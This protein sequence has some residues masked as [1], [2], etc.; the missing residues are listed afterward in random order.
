MAQFVPEI[1]AI[2]FGTSN[3][4]LAAANRTEVHHAVPLDPQAE[5]P[6]VLRSVLFFPD[7]KEVQQEQCF[8]GKSALDEYVARGSRGRLLRSLKRF[9]P[10]RGFV[11][12]QIG[13]RSYALEELIA[14][15][16]RELRVRADRFFGARVE[17]VLLGRPARFSSRQED[18]AFA[19]ERL[20]AAAHLAGFR[21][22]DFCPEPV[23]AARDFRAELRGQKLLL[24]GDFGGGTSD[25][26]LVRMGDRGFA[27]ENVLATHGVSVAGDALDG[28]LMRSRLA[29]HF[30]AEVRYRVPMGDNILSMPRP[31]MEKLCS[32]AEMSLLGQRD[33]QAFLQDVRGWSLGAEDRR[34]IDQLLTL[35][36][37]T[38]GFVVFEAVEQAKKQLSSE[39]RTLLSF[40]VPGI[41]ID[42][43]LTREELESGAR[44]ELG[45]IVTALDETLARAGVT[46]DAV[47]VVCLTGGSA[48][49]P[50]VRQA[51]MERF[52]SERLHSLSGLHAVV[53]GLARQA[54]WSLASGL[55][56][57]QD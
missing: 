21:H 42:Q 41:D 34:H 1:Y 53:D 39:Q 33:A 40:H 52:G 10:A 19:E 31:L 27:L 15:L 17:R 22:V 18:D 54:R 49:V 37:D 35:V 3:S 36:E 7:A 44:R 45:A 25:Y 47:D 55:G 29:R 43:E 6:T 28:S 13:S 14:A 9:L 23:A 32:P 11:R 5:D 51:L 56:S 12:T 50:R 16:L 30:G 57:R 8:F 2:D 26:S 20:R 38:L 48:R 46:A 24:V 4:L